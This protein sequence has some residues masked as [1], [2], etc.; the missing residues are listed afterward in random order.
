MTHV[1]LCAGR[2]PVDVGAIGLEET[3]PVHVFKW[4]VLGETNFLHSTP[5]KASV[6]VGKRR[7]RSAVAVAAVAA[8]DRVPAGARL[9]LGLVIAGSSVHFLC[10]CVCVCE[11]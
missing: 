6:T 2:R 3:Q 9:V 1:V 4:E 8:A 7:T 11:V 5:L 10:V